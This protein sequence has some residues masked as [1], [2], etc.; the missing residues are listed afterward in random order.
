M[1][2]SNQVKLPNS[3][4]YACPGLRVVK[5]KE[6]L[7]TEVTQSYNN[8]EINAAYIKT[9]IED[10]FGVSFEQLKKPSRKRQLVF[11]RQI[12]MWLMVRK[13][14]LSKV[15]IGKMYGRD[16]STVIHSEQTINNFLNHKYS[17]FEKTEILDFFGKY[18]F[19]NIQEVAQ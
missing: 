9:A 8:P 2:I 11:A 18:G 14:P 4:A 10:H 13:T 1:N 16:H 19:S 3:F 17:S 7:S 6:I 15:R 5:A 12:S